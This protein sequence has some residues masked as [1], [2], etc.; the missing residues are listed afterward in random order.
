MPR[1]RPPRPAPISAAPSRFEGHLALGKLLVRLGREDE[2]LAAYRRA[3]ELNPA[4]LAAHEEFN[5]LAWEM[6]QDVR[7]L[8]SHAFARTRAGETPELLLAE[9]ELLLRFRN[10]VEAAKAEALLARAGDGAQIASARGRALMLQNRFAEAAARFDR[11]VAA[12]PNAVGH[13]QDLAMALLRGR[14]AAAAR[15]VLGEAFEMAPEDQL[16][17]GLL[18]VAARA[19][20]DGIWLGR[21]AVD[22]WVQEIVP[23]VPHGFADMAAFNAVLAE[24]LMS[25]HTRKAAPMDQ[26]LNRGTKTPAQ[27]VLAEV[28]SAFPARRQFA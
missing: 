20:G 18:T 26:S 21:L 2:A 22:D 11:A 7:Q 1:P 6:G 13:R 12:E 8:G 5:Y 28:P 9:A 10:A 3:I 16:T 27:P 23:P 17:L 14:D 25:L 15:Q 19:L 24:E 4:A